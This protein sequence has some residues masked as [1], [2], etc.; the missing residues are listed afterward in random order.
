M[1]RI[2]PAHLVSKTGKGPAFTELTVLCVAGGN[3]DFKPEPQIN[4]KSFSGMCIKE[5]H[6]VEREASFFQIG[7]G[8]PIQSA[9]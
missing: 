2:H 8:G 9:R 5:R 4:L 6:M 1:S 7:S 3:I